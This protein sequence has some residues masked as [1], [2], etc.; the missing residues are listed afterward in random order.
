ML[1]NVLLRDRTER[2]RRE[3]RRERERGRESIYEER[4]RNRMGEKERENLSRYLGTKLLDWLTL[5]SAG[6]P[7]F[8][9]DLSFSCQFIFLMSTDMCK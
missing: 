1:V 6:P 4:Q 7:S 9:V 5:L 8:G 3:R 2:G